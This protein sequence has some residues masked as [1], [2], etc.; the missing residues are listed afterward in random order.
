V[1]DPTQQSHDWE[2]GVAS[3][4]LAWT[5]PISG[6]S[7]QVNP[8][9]GEARLRAVGV[10]V[11][12]FHDGVSAIFGGG[13]EPIPGHVSFDVRWAGHGDTQRIDDGTFGFRGRF[14]TGPAT[15]S[16]TASNDGDDV[17][18]TSDPDGQFNPGPEDNGAGPP[19]VGHEHN[20]IF[21]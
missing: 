6:S 19:A 20:G 12:D 17:V 10:A 16:F 1:G 14:V 4:G 7:L 11:S 13:P 5:I 3:S 8:G 21:F 9:T 18:Y 15:I 2:P